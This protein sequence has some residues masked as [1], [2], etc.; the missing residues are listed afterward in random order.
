MD[1]QGHPLISLTF[2]DG[3]NT[4]ITPMVLD[5]LEKYDIP[6]S[7]FLIADNLTEESEPVVRRACSMGCEI[8]NHSVTHGFMDQMSPE[9]ITEEY[10]R[11]SEKI[12]AVTGREPEFFR[13]PFIAV[14]QLMHDLI[15]LTF[16]SGVGCEDWV[17]DVPADERARRMLADARDGNLVLLHDMT[18]NINTVEALRTV[19]PALKE[20]GFRFLTCSAIF[21]ESGVTPVRNRL[22]SNVFQSVYR[23]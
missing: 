5:L 17:P 16:I 14:N 1:R 19:I 23:I 18:G 2:D 7:F 22:Y 3:P 12:T 6:A 8:E 4:A 15:P 11:C 10:T 9:K 20:R 21:R 13:P